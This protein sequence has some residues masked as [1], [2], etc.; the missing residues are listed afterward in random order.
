MG[1]TGHPVK[2]P[3]S[4]TLPDTHQASGLGGTGGQTWGVCVEGMCLCDQC[5]CTC[6]PVCG[7]IQVCVHACGHRCMYIY[8]P[9]V[10]VRGGLAGAEFRG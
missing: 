10:H 4:Q 3:Q 1:A 9:C 6:M 2:S 8:V 5:V 7:S